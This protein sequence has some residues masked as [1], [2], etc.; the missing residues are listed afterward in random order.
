[1]HLAG[2]T[3][4]LVLLGF[5]ISSSYG[6][7]AEEAAYIRGHFGYGPDLW[8]ADDFG[9]FYYDLDDDS[10][11]EEL[12]IDP[13]GRTVEKG[14][15]IYS[16]KSWTEEFQHKP[17]GS[18]SAVAFMGRPFLAG[19]RESPFTEEVLCLEKGE[20]REV[21]MDEEI[22]ETIGGNSTL[23]LSEGYVLVAPEVSEK[24]G[25]VS[26]LLLKNGAP[27]YAS[28]VAI[29][30][31]FVYKV[32]DV[33]VIIAHLENAMRGDEE[34]LAEIEGVFQISDAPYIRLFDG[35][36]I[37][38]MKLVDYSDEGLRFENNATIT[39]R[40]DTTIPLMPAL[41]LVVLDTDS[42]VYY[43]QGA[44][45]EYGVHEI[46][47]PVFGADASLPVR[48]GEYNST[49]M[50]RWN[51]ENYSGFYFDPEDA[52]GGETLVFFPASERRLEEPSHF[53]KFEENMTVFQKGLQ[54]TTFVQPKEFDYGPWGHYFTISLFGVPWFAGYDS[55]L[56]GS[57]A[58]KSLLE[59]ERLSRVLMDAEIEGNIVAGNYTLQDGYEMRIRDVGND[60]LFLQL[61]KDGGLVDSSVVGSNTTYVYE[62]DL[63]NVD[64]MPVIMM[65]FGNIFNNG[66]HSFAALDG[67]FQISDQYLFP[68]E[69]G[70]GFGELEI[71]GVMPDGII[72]VNNDGISLNRNSDVNIGPGMDVRVADNDSLRYYLYTS[73][74][75]VPAPEPPMIDYQREVQSYLTANFSLIVKAAEIRQVL[76]S[77]IAPDNK[78]VYARDITW[79][80]QGSGD[81][82]GFSWIWN[83][84][85]MQIGAGDGDGSETILDSGGVPVM[86]LL[87]L[88]GSSLPKQVGVLFE[89]GGSIGSI[90][91]AEAIYYISRDEYA[92]LNR[93]MD[94]DSMRDNSTER[95]GFIR[96]EPGRSV[97]Q[98]FDLIDNRWVMSGINHTIEGEI[99]AIEPRAFFS[100][101][102]PGRYELRVRI[103]N[104]V[105]AI[106]ATGDYFNV[107]EPGGLVPAAGPFGI[108]NGLIDTIDINALNAAG[109]ANSGTAN[110]TTNTTNGTEKDAKTKKSPAPGISALIAL[111]LSACY[112]R[113]RI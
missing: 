28:V 111:I 21:L 83:A 75:V 35:G 4:L 105:N 53:V 14:H 8:S 112:A 11:R 94:Y 95:A 56:L 91:D 50:A 16:S 107:T 77:I 40:R 70:N 63:E 67:I 113:R 46:R 13:V 104:A 7:E 37:G 79:L 42:L 2:A 69:T 58:K 52:I 10:G 103:E 27:V 44:F 12:S 1:M 100:G 109:T 78:T 88:N 62:R 108:Q 26:F 66:S 48:M 80:G 32:N 33:P 98:F 34:G 101:A 99:G 92:K 38:E 72:L 25:S 61:M 45:Y 17:W 47:G 84:T 6:Q 102:R 20:I 59:N 43:P 68:I 9:W 60:S 36:R 31:D 18:F 23:P 81:M 73:K 49:V 97:L 106:W 3:I 93:T 57:S 55:S 19:Y 86:A 41:D 89:P 51:F 30:D 64:E 82:W 76:V 5:A 110:T 87:Y 71:V 96:I 65:H 24:K 85:T 54:Y 15:L 74:Y 39:L 90:T 29:G 22:V